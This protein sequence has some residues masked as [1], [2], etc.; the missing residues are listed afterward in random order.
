[1]N[2]K[3]HMIMLYDDTIDLGGSKKVALLAKP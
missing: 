3:S 1:M 2:K